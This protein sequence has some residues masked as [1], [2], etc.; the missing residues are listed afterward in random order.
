MMNSS[1]TIM[2][3]MME[4][5]EDRIIANAIY[6]ILTKPG[7]YES[8]VI[9][10]GTP[11]PVQGAWAVTIEY[12]RGIGEQRFTLEQ[13]GNDLTGMQSGEI[14]NAKL[15]GS[16]HANQIELRSSMAVGG[17]SI[18]WTF[19]GTIEGSNIAGTV[20]MGEYGGATWK[21]IRA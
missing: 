4:A 15:K 8:P 2:P 17:N 6:E 21:A 20:H 3:Y 19:K 10:T 14:Y 16:V 18:P 7:P 1:V 13:S 5:G 11:A 9:P 12:L